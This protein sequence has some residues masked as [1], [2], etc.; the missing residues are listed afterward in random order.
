Y[1]Q[2]PALLLHLDV[3]PRPQPLHLTPV[4]YCLFHLTIPEAFWGAAL[5]AS[6]P[7]SRCPI[8]S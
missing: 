7:R 1:Q 8:S 4:I 2:L 3:S 5:S 6:V